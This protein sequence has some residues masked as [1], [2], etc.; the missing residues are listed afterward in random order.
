MELGSTDLNVF[1]KKLI[2][3]HNC[4]PE[5]TRVYYWKKMLEAVKAIHAKDIIHQDLKPSNFVVCGCEV[6]LI[7]FNISNAIQ[8]DKTSITMINDMGT[9]NYMAPETIISNRDN[10]IKV[11]FNLHFVLVLKFISIFFIL[12][13]N[14]K[15]DV[16]SLGVILYLMCYGKVPFFK[17]NQ[18]QI[19]HSLNDKNLSDIKY[20]PI[21]NKQILEIL[22]KCLC[23]DALERSSVD[24]LLSHEYVTK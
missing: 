19:I 12:K 22:K 20:P 7:D 4:V 18:Y 2:K 11:Y 23:Y 10:K 17:L 13:I 3:E 6:K 1:F 16:W 21:S 9:L 15:V 14:Q 24:E 8:S 5:P